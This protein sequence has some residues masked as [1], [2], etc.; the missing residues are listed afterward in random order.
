MVS[1]FASQWNECFF[2]IV[3]LFFIPLFFLL[4]FERGDEAV[5]NHRLKLAEEGGLSARV[6]FVRQ[7]LVRQVGRGVAAVAD[8]VRSR[9]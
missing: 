9:R 8:R 1:S 3:Q 7:R 6:V 5:E 4:C 2:F